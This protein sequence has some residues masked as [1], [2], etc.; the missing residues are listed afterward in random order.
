MHNQ[1]KR[2]IRIILNK[3]TALILGTRIVNVFTPRAI[4]LHSAGPRNV[5][6][7]NWKA[8]LSGAVNSWAS[9]K[10]IVLVLVQLQKLQY[11]KHEYLV[12]SYH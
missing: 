12:T 2:A 6:L 4:Y 5:G 10:V 11:H 3:D 7:T 8:G 1:L 9:A